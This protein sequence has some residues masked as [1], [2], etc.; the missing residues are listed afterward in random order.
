M[1]RRAS[2]HSTRI[3]A[4]HIRVYWSAARSGW[5]VILSRAKAIGEES[6]HAWCIL[7]ARLPFAVT[8]LEVSYTAVGMIFAQIPTRR[9]PR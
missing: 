4:R 5:S 6:R 8:R 7:A 1:V 2:Q 9:H 3:V